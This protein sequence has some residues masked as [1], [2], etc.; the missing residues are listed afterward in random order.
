MR[1]TAET[2]PDHSERLN[3][4]TAELAASVFEKS[5]PAE[6]ARYGILGCLNHQLAIAQK[7]LSSEALEVAIG[8]PFSLGYI[9]GVAAWYSDRSGVPRPSPDADGLVLSAY[10]E[11]LGPLCDD[12]I[13]T[14]SADAA[15]YPAF[16]EGMAAAATELDLVDGG[17]SAEAYALARFLL[18]PNS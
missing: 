10:K 15:A 6:T 7:I 18:S 11:L 9:F 8:S 16:E 14:I 13:Q 2:R 1:F 5:T 3:A 4:L 12:E 17:N